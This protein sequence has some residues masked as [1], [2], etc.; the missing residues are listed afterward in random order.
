MTQPTTGPLQSTSTVSDPL[1]NL[2][3]SFFLEMPLGLPN[4]VS[5]VAQ[6]DDFTTNY[7]NLVHFDTPYQL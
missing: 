2:H 5:G 3:D 1:Y 4:N 7:G 6:W